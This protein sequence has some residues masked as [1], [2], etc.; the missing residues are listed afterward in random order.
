MYYVENKA[1]LDTENEE[2]EN[3]I[4]YCKVLRCK[5][6]KNN[7]KVHFPYVKLKNLISL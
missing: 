1:I 4:L 7:K 6:I 3:K 2:N 5:T